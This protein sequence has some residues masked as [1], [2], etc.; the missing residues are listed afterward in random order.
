EIT[1][2]SARMLFIVGVTWMTCSLALAE[3]REPENGRD[4]QEIA[5]SGKKT[6]QTRC[7]TCHD[8]PRDRIPPRTVLGFIPPEFIVSAMTHGKM[9]QMAMGLK[10]GAIDD[11]ATFLTGKRPGLKPRP[12][13]NRCAR[14][15][16]EVHIAKSDW[17]SVDRDVTG[18]R[19]QPEPG[20]R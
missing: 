5:A 11:V 12:L 16:A 10:P 13:P 20:L 18:S 8:H 3:T 1:T 19:F 6:Y 2:R 17:P 7:A 9:K 15:G 14:P 4:K